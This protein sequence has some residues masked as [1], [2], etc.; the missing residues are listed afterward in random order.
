MNPTKEVEEENKNEDKVKH[1]LG[2]TESDNTIATKENIK[3][4]RLWPK[5]M[6]FPSLQ[7]S[8]TQLR[9]VHRDT[10]SFLHAASACEVISIPSP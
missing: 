10:C 7:G 8:H 6:M 2:T 9:C 4:K 3:K 1:K 5:D